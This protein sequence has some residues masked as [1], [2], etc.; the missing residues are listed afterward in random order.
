MVTAF[1]GM[2]MFRIG[3]GYILGIVC[4]V[5]ILGIWIAMYIDWIVRGTLYLFRVRGNKWIMHR[6]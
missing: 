4:N 5:G 1:V 2:W 6:V 3:L